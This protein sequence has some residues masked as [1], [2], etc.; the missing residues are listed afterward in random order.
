[1]TDAV[2][3]KVAVLAAKN[4]SDRADP[5]CRLGCAPSTLAA[6]KATAGATWA[7]HSP[8][9]MDAKPLRSARAE[10]MTSSWS[11]K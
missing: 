2:T 3:D 9:P 10:M 6:Y 7:T 1:M 11:S 4:Q 5:P 8:N